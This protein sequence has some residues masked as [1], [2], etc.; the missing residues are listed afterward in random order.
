MVEIIF[1][2]NEQQSTLECKPEEKIKEIFKK[3][4]L[5][6]SKNIDSLYFSFNGNK[7][8][9]ELTITQFINKSDNKKQNIYNC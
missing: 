4:A 6:E 1:I 7:I 3:Y 8:N 5:K 2:F 9:Q